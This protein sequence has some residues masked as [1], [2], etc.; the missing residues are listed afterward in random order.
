MVL[1][2]A[3]CAIIIWLQWS[4]QARKQPR[5]RTRPVVCLD[6][7]HPSETNPATILQHGTTEL[8]INWTIA[9]KLRDALRQKGIDVVMTKRSRD[10]FLSNRDRA[11]IANDCR[12][13]LAVHLHCDAGPGRGYTVYYP[14]RQGCIEGFV[15]PSAEVIESSRRA[16]YLLHSGMSPVLAGALHDRGVR[17]DDKTKIGR[18]KGVLTTSC[19][20][21]VPTV[22]V[23]MCFLNNLHDNRFIQSPGGQSRLTRALSNGIATYLVTNGCR[24]RSGKLFLRH[25]TAVGAE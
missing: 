2:I 1:I 22:T 15:G 8:E 20:S 18:S 6:P 12:A 7:G 9:L 5:I 16:A 3:A 23:E 11:F 10:Q 21:E 4:R 25:P 19:F 17:G 14:N 24:Q 13:D